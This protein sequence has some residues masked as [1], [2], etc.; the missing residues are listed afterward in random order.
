[1][2]IPPPTTVIPYDTI[3]VAMNFARV[4][5]NDCPLNLSGNILTDQQPYAQTTANLA[6]RMFQDDLD[7]AGEPS[8]PE[9]INNIIA[10]KTVE[11]LNLRP[12]MSYGL[13]AP[14]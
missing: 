13:P 14:R 6:W 3:D 2:P 9:N 4:A 7:E 10:K 8:F 12:T 5:L 11:I 1:M